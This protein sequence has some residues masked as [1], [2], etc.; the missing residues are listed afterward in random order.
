MLKQLKI[1]AIAL[2][3]FAVF[4]TGTNAAVVVGVSVNGVRLVSEAEGEAFGL[5]TGLVIGSTT[6]SFLFNF[7]LA[8]DPSADSMEE[9]SSDF[10]TVNFTASEGSQLQ[11]PANYGTAIA[12]APSVKSFKQT[13]TTAGSFEGSLSFSLRDSASSYFSMF[14]GYDSNPVFRF[15]LFNYGTVFTPSPYDVQPP[16]PHVPTTVT[17]TSEGTNIPANAPVV[18]DPAKSV[19]VALRAA[20]P[21]ESTDMNVGRAATPEPGTLM[22]LGFGLAAMGVVRFRK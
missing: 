1:T 4:T 5:P 21:D 11:A 19:A 2:A 9:I 16:S 20:L 7:Q 22:M 18:V 17:T 10:L 3:T 6:G 12:S 8:T 13:Y 15:K 14:G